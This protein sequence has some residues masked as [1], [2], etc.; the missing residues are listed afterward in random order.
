V[1]EEVKLHELQCETK[2]SVL[3]GSGWGEEK[4]LLKVCHVAKWKYPLR[5]HDN[6]NNCLS[7]TGVPVT[8]NTQ[9]ILCVHSYAKIV[10]EIIHFE[11]KYLMR[12]QSFF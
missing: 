11:K 4:V 7:A 3:A 6:C 1:G 5:I 8:Q 2:W 10:K 12:I 9:I